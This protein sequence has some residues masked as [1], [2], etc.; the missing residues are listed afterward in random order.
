MSDF[1]FSYLFLLLWAVIR[2]MKALN[3]ISILVNLVVVVLVI[4]I[5]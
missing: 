4:S 5:K 1:D 2:K 3:N